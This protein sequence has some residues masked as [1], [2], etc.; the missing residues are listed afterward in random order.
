[1]IKKS[2]RGFSLSEIIITLSVIGVVAALTL[3]SLVANYNQKVFNAMASDF[4]SQL[5]ETLKVMNLKKSLANKQTTEIFVNEMKKYFKITKVCDNSNLQ[6]CFANKI[7]WGSDSEEIDM[8]EITK[9]KNF[10]HNDWHTNIVGLQFANGINAVVAYNPS[11]TENP[12]SNQVISLVAQRNRSSAN[13]STNTNN[14]L[15]I[16]YDTNGFKQPNTSTKDVRSINIKKI[17]K[18]CFLEIENLCIMGPA[19]IP[20]AHVWNSCQADGTSTDP[21]DI[22]FMAEYDIPHCFIGLAV[23]NGNEDYWAGAIEKCGGRDKM[24]TENELV[25]IANY[26]YNVN[27]VSADSCTGVGGTV[28]NCDGR[29][30]SLDTTKASALGLNSEYIKIWTDSEYILGDNTNPA[31]A[32]PYTGTSAYRRGF[33]SDSTSKQFKYRNFSDTF[34]LCIDN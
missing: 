29:S 22:A 21:E 25:T 14:C 12:F 18:G 11:C 20:T 1:M 32:D 16:L 4:E 13:I 19:E 30:I 8:S 31:F 27:F 24:P 3:P 9:A 23:P 28:D 7:Y 2:N 34:V 15:A 17:G 10:G 6:S 26:L 5:G 33:F